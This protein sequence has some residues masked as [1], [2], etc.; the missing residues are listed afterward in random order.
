MKSN[1]LDAIV[2]VLGYILSFINPAWQAGL[3][4]FLARMGY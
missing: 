3:G 4:R 1:L 2:L